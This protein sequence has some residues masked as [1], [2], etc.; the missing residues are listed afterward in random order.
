MEE[1]GIM[2][3]R[4]RNLAAILGGVALLMALQASAGAAANRRAYCDHQ[5]RDFANNQVAGNAVGGALGGALLGAGIGAL[6]GGG[7]GAGTG[8]AIG[9]GAG[10][11]GGGANGSAQWNQNYWGAF[12]DCMNGN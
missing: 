7:H 3:T 4:G 6:A 2:Q 9:A 5:A 1:E 12:N 11:L 8:A 10:A